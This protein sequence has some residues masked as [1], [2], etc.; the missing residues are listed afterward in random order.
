MVWHVIQSVD[1]V[2][3][4]P[5]LYRICGEVVP[6]LD[7]VMRDSMPVDQPFSKPPDSGAD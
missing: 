7:A 6:L 5:F 3:L 4:G 2:V 1:P